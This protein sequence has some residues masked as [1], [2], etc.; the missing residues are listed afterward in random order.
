MPT[1]DDFSD[2]FANSSQ[3]SIGKAHAPGH[4]S[5]VGAGPGNP[6]LM[7][8]AAVRALR[9]ADV[10]L[11]DDLV[12]PDCLEFARREA[13]RIQVGKT[14]HGP[15][16]RQDDI[17]AHMI[18]LAKSGQRVV[19]LKSGDP[20]IFGRAREEI[21]ALR[22][23]GVAV[24]IVSGVTAAQAAAASL[25][26]SLT[27]REMARRV[28]F[29]TGHAREGHLPDDIDWQALA[30]PRATTAAYMPLGTLRELLSGLLENG[31]EATRSAAAVFS[32]SRPEERI[33][34][35]TVATLAD[36]VADWQDGSPG[37]PRAKSQPCLVLIGEVVSAAQCREGHT[38]RARSS[39]VATL[40]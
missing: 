26:V 31:V 36:R 28:Q 8:L 7:T 24:S 34:V 35:G 1:E 20:M 33:I 39:R 19:R 10:I 11:Y 21:E 9:S 27:E 22:G 40:A 15:S 5:L 3:P 29:V 23:A 14:G 12:A 37:Q 17:N 25:Q 30:D 32:A 2:L 13:K 4:V 16:C 6:E 18:A 38:A